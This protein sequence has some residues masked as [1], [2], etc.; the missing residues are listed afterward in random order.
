MN[1]ACEYA[2]EYSPSEQGRFPVSGTQAG[3]VI[4]AIGERRNA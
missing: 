2:P 4:V 1:D 3:A